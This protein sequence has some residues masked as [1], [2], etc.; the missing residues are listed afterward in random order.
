MSDVGRSPSAS[1]PI[2]TESAGQARYA[3]SGYPSAAGVGYG[4]VG[5][6]PVERDRLTR[7]V[8]RLHARAPR[9]AVP[10]AALGCI[11]AAMGYTL[12]SNPTTSAPDALPTCLLKLTTGLDCPGCGGTRAMWY[13]LHGDVPA[14]AR[15]HLVW[16]FVLPFL[17]YLYVSWAA[18]RIW[19]RRLPQ[20]RISPRT[21]GVTLAAWAV[22]SV[23]RNLPWAPFTAFYV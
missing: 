6:P 4:A 8:L 16:V 20:L 1:A 19:G 22:F 14:A 23:A 18:E 15:H 9:W 11:G 7:F 13:L 5:Y 21:L 3:A 10:V 12:L 17:L 2:A